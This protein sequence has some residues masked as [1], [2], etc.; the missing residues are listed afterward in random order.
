MSGVTGVLLNWKRPDNVARIVAGWRASGIVDEGIVWNNN[1]DVTLSLDGWATV[2]NATRDLG[3][4]TRFTAACL[5]RNE[6][7]L[8]QDDD[9]LLPAESIATLHEAWRSRPDIL[10]GV[11][12]RAPNA[13]GRY[14]VRDLIGADVP[15]VLTRALLT[16]RLHA[17]RFFEFAAAFEALQRG[18]RPQGNGEDIL[19]SYAVMRH[20]GRLNRTHRV[21]V[22]ELPSPDA[23]NARHRRRHFAHRMQLMD[24]CIA[25]LRGEA[26]PS[27]PE[28]AAAL[29]YRDRAA[30]DLLEIAREA[31]S[32]V[33]QRGL[34]ALRR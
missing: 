1:P 31:L 32:I 17:A 12:G 20:S 11:F 8:I 2:V 28:L 7:V 33:W 15:V 22:L 30:G 3:L 26:S 34:R 16:H 14:V 24:A 10:H 4:Y 25:R 9:I 6:C 27:R 29:A 18:G 5:A 23:I 19:F 21:P 13:R